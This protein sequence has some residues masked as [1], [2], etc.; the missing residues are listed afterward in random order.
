MSKLY[1]IYTV[2][3]YIAMIMNKLQLQIKKIDVS[4]KCN[5]AERNKTPD[6]KQKYIHTVWFN[7]GKVKNQIKLIYAVRSQDSVCPLRRDKWL[8]KEEDK[9]L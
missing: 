1:F 3:F 4:H 5:I 6:T 2:E 9:C 7:L 8:G